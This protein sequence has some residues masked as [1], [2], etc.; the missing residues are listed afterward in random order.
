[1]YKHFWIVPQVTL[2]FF[3]RICNIVAQQL[4]V[5][6]TYLYLLLFIHPR[7]SVSIGKTQIKEHV[8]GQKVRRTPRYREHR[9]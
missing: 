8:V 6:L 7:P 4:N 5:L 9:M 3:P 2:S 1:M